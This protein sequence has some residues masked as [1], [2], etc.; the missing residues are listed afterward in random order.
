VGAGLQL[1]DGFEIDDRRAVDAQEAVAREL[2][3]D[4]GHRF[5]QQVRFAAGVQ[6]D[7][8]ACRLDP[9]DLLR[10]EEHHVPAIAHRQAADGELLGRRRPQQGGQLALQGGRSG[11]QLAE[12]PLADLVVDVRVSESQA[13][14]MT[15]LALV[16]P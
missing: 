12:T 5:A 15:S 16:D 8:V 1:A 4:P 10:G 13:H 14:E 3:L 6:A 11:E 2:A 9:L 7:V